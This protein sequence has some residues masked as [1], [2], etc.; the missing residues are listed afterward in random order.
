MNTT[1][2]ADRTPRVDLVIEGMTCASCVRRVENALSKVPGVTGASV[3]LATETAEVELEQPIDTDLL[4][5]AIS[6][7]G[8]GA[9]LPT[10]KVTGRD[11]I[12][13]EVSGM[14]CASCVRRVENALS[15]VPGVTG[16]SVN[17]ATETAEV[18]L[19]RPIDTD[20][21]IGA[22]S[23]AGYGAEIVGASQT[24]EEASLARQAKR[25][26]EL[27][28]RRTRLLVGAVLSVGVLVIGY[29]FPGKVWS[30]PVELV[31]STP[32]YLWVGWIFHRTTI[33]N[34][35]HGAVNMDTLVSLGSTVAYAY[36][37]VATL[38]L[39]GKPTYFDVASLIITLIS[40]GKYLELTARSHAGESLEALMTLR[41]VKA[42]LLA[43]ADSVVEGDRTNAADVP[44]DALRVG[45]LVLVRPGEAV[46]TD[47]AV[48]EGSSSLD[49]SLVT[50]E[51][52]PVVRGPGDAVVGG[53]INSLTPLV[54][55][56]TRTGDETI[57][58]QV[59]AAVQKAQLEKSKV[60]TLADSV[61]AVFVPVIIAI[62]LV[63]FV[64]WMLSGHD[65][66]SS[67]MPAVAVLVIACPC[68]LGLATPVAT[69]VGTTKGAQRGILLSGGDSL[70]VAK[71]IKAI[72]LD[73]TGTLTLGQPRVVQQI[74]LDGFDLAEVL[75][76]AATLEAGS[77]HPLARAIVEAGFR[78]L[79]DNQP[80]I[81]KEHRVEP[82]MGV[83]GRS[84]GGSEHEYLIGSLLYLQSHG[85]DVDISG[86]RLDE[87]LDEHASLVALAI[88]GE[89]GLLLGIADPVR[90]DAKVGIERL[91]QLGLKVILASGDR[92]EVAKNVASDLRMDDVYFELRPQDKADL[93]VKMKERYGVV[94]M[95]GDGINDA[96]ALARADVGIAVG[97][98]TAIAM[99]V[100]DMT[101]VHGDVSAIADAIALSRATRRIIWQNLGWALGYNLLLVPL[102]A[103]G[104]VPPILAAL[105]MATSSVSVVA[106]SLRLRRFKMGIDSSVPSEDEH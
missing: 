64:G 87:E 20:Q 53:S 36:S 74:V 81:L 102:A 7:A 34:A 33:K 17:L 77:E 58:A 105:A 35:R 90:P 71:Y 26:A 94:A 42:H 101:I 23:S 69:L 3:N 8:Y 91:Q 63:T 73:K 67:L 84:G 65:A 93:V 15:K 61:S 98:G 100:A 31:L 14:T 38:F 22:V 76:I 51:S 5:G 48:V 47:G 75:A 103:F 2:T 37:L 50:G 83:Y 28:V 11:L 49:E 104:Q 60:Q 68:A 29:G 1:S 72:V 32:V 86:Y 9:H 18:E 106:N 30:D 62:S 44:V 39:S 4:I 12:V 66:L 27:G 46:P 41:P 80:I 92:V 45:D 16:A 52:M 96:P 57:L 89:V 70:E 10:L 24:L 54:M 88:D 25:K 79:A 56:V 21:L 6:S 13:L 55:R 85:V 97:S 82:G 95:V 40:L 99:S 78:Y 19:E 43:R 59:V